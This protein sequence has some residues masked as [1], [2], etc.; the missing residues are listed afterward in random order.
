MTGKRRFK[1]PFWLQFPTFRNIVMS[2]SPGANI[3]GRRK[4]Q[5]H[6]GLPNSEDEGKPQFFYKSVTVYQLTKRHITEWQLLQKYRSDNI[7]SLLKG[8]IPLC[9]VKYTIYYYSQNTTHARTRWLLQLDYNPVVINIWS[10][11]VL[12]FD[13]TLYITYLRQK[14]LLIMA[15]LRFDRFYL[16]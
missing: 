8:A 13:G 10:L 14:W 15:I 12:Y 6:L 1:V 3:W 9:I 7:K 2:L 5:N 11:H 4:E 16:S